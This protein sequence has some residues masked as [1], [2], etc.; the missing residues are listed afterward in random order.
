M[1][2]L[3][4]LTGP[5]TS[6]K[7]DTA[8][9]L[10]EKLNTEIINADSMQVYK[11]FDIGTAK[12]PAKVRQR[13]V[14]HLIDI[15]EPDEE[16]NAFDFKV[17][18]LKHVREILR[19]GK[20]PII[21]G[22]T[23]L[24][25]K[26]LTQDFDCAA[27]ISADIKNAIQSE[28]REKGVEFMHEELKGIDPLYASS[29]K[30]TDAIRIERALGVYRQTGRKFSEFHNEETPATYE[31][32]IK[33]FLL[34]WD[35]QDLYDNIDKRVDTMMEMGLV[36]EVKGLLNRGYCKTL[37]PF[38]SIGY[39]QVINYLEGSIPLERAV[40]EI[41]RDTRH[42]A[43]RQITWFKKVPDTIPIPADNADNP[44]SL[45]DKILSFLPQSVALMLACILCFALPTIGQTEDFSSYQKGVQQFTLGHY[46][47]A[48]NHLLASINSSSNSENIKR[49]HYLLAHINLEKNNTKKA[50]DLFL[51]S[52]KEYPEIEDYVRFSL[53]QAFSRQGEN[54]AALK[55]VTHLLKNFPKT[56]TYP[57]AQL[58]HA[59]ILKK[60]GKTEQAIS[61]LGQADQ[62]ISKNSATD[63]LQESLAEIISQQAELHLE[64]GQNSKAYTLYRKLF[65][66]HPADPITLQVLPEMKRLRALPDVAPA[67]ISYNE[68]A[69]RIKNLLGGARFEQVIQEIQESYPPGSQMPEKYY[70]YLAQ[71]YQS[72]KKRAEANQTLKTFLKRYPKHRR[73]DEAQYQI[74]RNLW[75]LGKDQAAIDFLKKSK[76]KNKV[77]NVSIKSQFIIGRIYEGNKQNS[78]ALKQYNHVVAQF[79]N[80][81]YAQWAAWRM[82]WIH[83]LSNQYQKA[84]DQ[85]KENARHYPKG[86]FIEYNL[87]WQGKSLETLGKKE[88][89]HK[90]YRD[91]AQNYPYTY[92][93]IRARER[94]NTYSAP[95][96]SARE[97]PY[98]V[99]KIALTNE[100]KPPVQLDRPLVAEERIH[101]SKAV[102][103][104]QLGF[105][106][107]AKR[108]ISS[109]Q[110]SVRKN[111]AGVMWLSSL[112]NEARAFS[113]SVRLLHLYRDYRSKHGEKDL[114]EQ[115]W[116]YFFPLAYAETIQEASRRYDIDPYFVKGLIRQ[117]SLFDAKALSSA[118]A[119]GVMQIMPETG[120]R[121]YA[122]DPNDQLYDKDLLFDPDL[123][124][125]LGIKY[126]S[127]LHKKFGK[128]GTHIL[129]SYN[130]GP[131]VL[132]K[133]LKRFRN[134]KDPDVFIESIPY[135]ETRGYVKH[136][137]RNHGV[138]KQLYGK[139]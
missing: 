115:F 32:P 12:P 59:D 85:F 67:P 135:P 75:N 66:Q 108:E 65:I 35:R 126:L 121:L 6:K 91:V 123:N 128:N 95:V 103:M 7:S 139:P 11:Y 113:E 51:K 124:I 104:T 60:L 77:S 40:Y 109:L 58:L 16:F 19:Q 105:Y 25:I 30:T 119:R 129:I 24:Y 64:L 79:G 118:G 43:K 38:N 57:Q 114:S 116:K 98:R 90:F 28:I 8:V 96:P 39:A 50:V 54:E 17:R 86:D 93:G 69:I 73:A 138:Y 45:R 78:Q 112:Y 15:L 120:K 1:I 89:A 76:K 82:G 132:K 106:E 36:D 33:T 14:H 136:V 137:S 5:T 83:Y 102:E 71:A 130:A 68:R 29:I 48:E 99:K 55:Q 127:Q 88:A 37:K 97:T 31:F 111:L 26:V 3:I 20:I 4:I 133:W 49:S 80:A 117:E 101:H 56:I 34:Q 100:K 61:A 46:S 62:W 87:Y 42:Y 131:H 22:G 18:A 125:Q 63:K 13:V 9:A 72:L 47:K 84:H 23:G 134:I 110:K 107:N 122:S 41:K 21:V 92:Y 81:E 27:P 2:P 52:L 94:V 70:F 74:G 10:A 53:A 44:E